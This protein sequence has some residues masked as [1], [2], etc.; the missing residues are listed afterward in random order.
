[1]GYDEAYFEGQVSKSDSKVAWQY[2]RLLKK[3][4]LNGHN[5]GLKVL[6]AGCGAGPA[7]RY[8]TK[9]GFEAFGIDFLAY[10]LQLAA[11]AVPA[12]RL[13]CCDLNKPLPFADGSF[14]VLFLSEVIEHLYNPNKALEE[15]RRV[16]KEDGVLVLT[17][18]NTWD[19]RRLIYP[20]LG[21]TWSGKADP[22]HVNLFNP[23]NLSS[24]L[25]TAG[26]AAVQVGSG[27]KPA[28]FLK[29]PGLKKRW[30][31][32][33]PPMIGN[34]LIG[35]ARGHLA[36]APQQG[37]T[38]RPVRLSALRCI[39]LEVSVNGLR[40][41]WRTVNDFSLW[42]LIEYPKV[43]KML[44]LRKGEMVLDVGSG[45]S[46]Y[47]LMLVKRGANVVSLE[48]DIKRVR[49]Q[50]EKYLT[51]RREGDGVSYQIVADARQLPFK[52]GTFVKVDS[53]SVIEHIPDDKAVAVE[54]GRVL[55]GGGTCV[56]SVPYTF[57]ERK[58]FFEGLKSFVKVGRNEFRQ[59]GKN[60]LVR[61]YTEA[62]LKERFGGAIGP[63]VEK[64][65]FGRRILN[66]AYH[67]TKLNRYWNKFIVKD[68][69]LATL[70]HPLEEA[71]LRGTEPFDVIFKMIKRSTT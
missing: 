45:T 71:F 37:R 61:F 3:A 18:A 44:D 50:R 55:R 30:E 20:V 43:T 54:M 32:P 12:A 28:F 6:D 69:F 35:A 48:L 21:R 8:L 11:Q 36:G 17:T 19:I 51:H 59:E 4:G 10:P 15:C 46:S 33:Y 23:R 63:V 58:G 41:L 24:L 27:F 62:D 65:Y 2:G 66:D 29:L 34:G 60:N 57:Q 31:L 9:R 16:L 1:M 42:R 7:L 40:S 70:V 64:S 25:E 68:W 13:A 49:W 53:I 26:F 5:P 56:I 38:G 39:A 47:P 67:E 52:D 22:T 14:D